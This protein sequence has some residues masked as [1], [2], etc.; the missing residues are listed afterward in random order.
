MD[1]HHILKERYWE[2][3]LWARGYFSNTSGNV[4][5]DIIN[6]YIDKHEDGNPPESKNDIRLEY[7]FSTKPDF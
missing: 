4:T 1:F 2:K 6:S 3:H 5:D 7:C